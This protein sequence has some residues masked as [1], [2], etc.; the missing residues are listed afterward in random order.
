MSADIQ[1]KIASELKLLDEE[2]NKI[3]DDL[4]HYISNKGPVSPN[5][6]LIC[7]KRIESYNT[8]FEIL[9]QDSLKLTNQV[10]NC[11]ELSDRLS[12]V[13]RHLDTKSLRVEAVIGCCENFIN[14]RQYKS[15]I[16]DAI[17]AGDL[18]IAISY[19]DRLKH[20]ELTPEEKNNEFKFI[21]VFQRELRKLL[22]ESFRKAINEQDMSAVVRYCPLLRTV[23]LEAE[24]RDVF[25]NFA[26]DTIFNAISADFVVNSIGG[27]TTDPAAAYAEALSRIFNTTVNIIQ[28]YLPI[29]IEG[30]ESVHGMDTHHDTYFIV[31][32]CIE[33]LSI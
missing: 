33:E 24:A 27:N 2:E 23:D 9:S 8:S 13:I 25:V 28:K 20:I 7:L 16:E 26:K 10:K 11:C 30:L 6:L 29:V 14:L 22:D 4:E 15:K 12:T 32:N 3:N 31:R 21:G 19:L 1:H 18:P 17:E 5:D